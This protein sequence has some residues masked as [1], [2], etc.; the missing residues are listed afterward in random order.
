MTRARP[1]ATGPLW[2]PDLPRDLTRLLARVPSGCV[3]TY[4][5]LATA[6]GDVV[7][8]RWCAEHLLAHPH[9]TSCLCHRVVRRN[10]EVGLYGAG[11]VTEKVRRLRREGIVLRRGKVDLINRTAALPSLAHAPLAR[12]RNQQT[13]ILARWNST[14]LPHVPRWIA[15]V[16]VSYISPARG[17][18]AYVLI[19]SQTGSVAFRRILERP[20]RFPYISSYL[21]FRELPL[22]LELLDQALTES[23]RP[24]V[25][26]VDGTGIL[27]PRHAGIATHLGILTDIPTVGVTKTLLCGSPLGEIC[28]AAEFVP[29]QHRDQHLGWAVRPRETSV[30][31]LYVSPGHRVNL[32]GTRAAI[33]AML[34]GRRLPEPLYWADRLSRQAARAT[35]KSRELV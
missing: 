28:H 3:T 9:D 14:P 4:G 30:H 32:N 31:T 33:S 21:T 8:A 23:A 26:L 11:G 29:I 27:H 18:A 13:D 22:L 1:S 12:L 15:G 10:G 19:D 20:V 25:I 35:K 34:L 17:V 2:I 24:D 16:D 7:A 5:Q 6:L